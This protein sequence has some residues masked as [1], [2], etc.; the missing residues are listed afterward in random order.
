M[1]KNEIYRAESLNEQANGARSGRSTSPGGDAQPALE[2]A[3]DNART[4]FRLE[5]LEVFNWGTFHGRVWT[6]ETNG[7]TALMTGANGSGKSTLVDALLTLLV[8]NVKR[9]YNLA[10]GADT[11]KERDER[12]YVLGAYGKFRGEESATSRT[13]Y[14]REKQDD[15]SVILASFYNEG[16]GQRVV[17]AHMF[18]FQN[19]ELRKF[20]VVSPHEMSIAGHFSE[21][22]DVRSLRARLRETGAQVFDQFNDYSRQFRRAFGMKS[23]KALDLFNQT[24][25]IKVIGDLNDF[26][27]THMLE[28]GDARSYIS[29]LRRHFDDLT[30][31]FEAIQKAR[32][33][34]EKLRPIDG[35]GS[36]YEKLGRRIAELEETLQAVPGVFAEKETAL[37]R[38]AVEAASAR[39][40]A[41]RQKHA[42]A[43]SALVEL[44]AKEREL[45][46]AI[47]RDEVG[48][49]IQRIEEEIR[50]AEEERNRL[51]KAW[52]R[53]REPASELELSVPETEE[54]FLRQRTQA[55]SSRSGS[56]EAFGALT[57]KRDEAMASI[58]L[59]EDEITEAHAELESLRERTNQIP[60][61]RLDLRRRLLQDLKLSADDLPFIG[62]L[63]Q[64]RPE[65]SAWEGAAERL[66]HGFALRVLVPERHYARVST[67]V[68][69]THLG[70]RLVYCRVPEEIRPRGVRD[71]DPDRLYN[72]LDVR[73]DTPFRDWLEA[74]LIDQYTHVCCD[75]ERFRHEQRAIT[76]NGL[77]KQN[78]TVHE[79]DDRHGLADR[80]H[81]VLGWDNREKIRLIQEELERLEKE[82][83][84]AARSVRVL[85][86]EQKT[87]RRRIQLWDSL[88]RFTEFGEI[89]KAGASRRIEELRGQKKRL[90]ESSDRLRQLQ[91]ERNAM[92]DRLA[93]ADA[94]VKAIEKQITLLE[95]S[96][97]EYDHRLE[98]CRG[99]LEP[100]EGVDL[101]PYAE[102]ITRRMDGRLELDSVAARRD[103]VST[104]LLGEIQEHRENRQTVVRRIELAMQRF[105][106]DFPDETLEVDA[107]IDALPEYRRRLETLEREDLPRYEERFRELLNK[108]LMEDVSFFEE[109]L[110]RQEEEIREKIE[111]LNDSLNDIDYS[112]SSYIQ[113]VTSAASDTEI[114]EFKHLLRSVFADNTG[115]TAAN[116]ASFH[117]IRDLILRFETE[118]RWTAKVTDVRNWVDFSISERY[119]ESGG[120]KNFITNSDG[121]SGG[122]KAKLAYTILAAAIAYQ[123]GLEHGETKSRSFRFVVI[124]EAFSKIDEDNARYAMEL[125]RKLDLQLLVVS[126]LGATR[127]VEDYIG[128]CQFIANDEDGS[129]SQVRNLTIEEYHEEKERVLA[130]LEAST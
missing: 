122:Q 105:K 57:P 44:R 48:Q 52:D 109:A 55:A 53:Y 102:R 74:E 42:A 94:R 37:L 36:R 85:E 47:S 108:K 19:G 124:D 81:Y 6:V 2:F 30:R 27:R 29:D 104:Q 1:R 92:R 95:K 96:L 50:H 70:D 75:V 5:R 38:E 40:A 34:V 83:E 77:I 20:F 64:V 56:E 32:E 111:A 58:R 63:V 54:Q 23:D 62:E 114:R 116:E 31:T 91:A 78:R 113:L 88:L 120:E 112:S 3:T 61:R 126:P 73:P 4:G 67:Y 125:F 41:E 110:F 99:A 98:R 128:A 119:S 10:S 118:E 86:E 60:R 127:V 76:K 51:R 46:I 97:E 107:S 15:Y 90:E 66:L 25:S 115:E 16:F 49:Q 82:R 71:Q 9:G 101:A 39:R 17:L 14:L 80:R 43:Q 103:G 100:Y 89:D 129:R 130:A 93:R 69:R 106:G 8:P 87:L 7:R 123:F 117:R 21:I 65:E 45:D 28:P 79:K 13:R 11:K 59:L 18:Y 26:V 12:S 33:Q 121:L 24:V 72:K 35:D 84:G 22:G 68:D